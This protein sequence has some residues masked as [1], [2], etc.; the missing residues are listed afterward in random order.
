MLSDI[1][2]LE[3][4]DRN[5]REGPGLS[6]QPLLSSSHNV[7]SHIE[8][9][10]SLTLDLRFHYLFAFRITPPS[11]MRSAVLTQSISIVRVFPLQTLT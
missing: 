9:P 6:S 8:P 7:C 10:V 4:R 1:T 3:G 2:A 5:P 11:L